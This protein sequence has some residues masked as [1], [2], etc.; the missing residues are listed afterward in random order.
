MKIIIHRGTHQIGGCVTEIKTDNTRMFIDMGSELDPGDS[1]SLKIE[2]VTKGESE[3]DAVLFS[4]YHGDHIGMI[5][6]INDDIPIYIGKAAKEILEIFNEQTKRYSVNKVAR[7][8]TYRQ[9][10]P[11]MIGELK[12]TPFS[13]DHSAYDSYMFLIE[14]NGFR[15]LHTGDFRTTGFR[16]K[17]VVPMLSKY[18]GKIDVLIT[19]G[20]LLTRSNNKMIT[21][22]DIM[23]SAKELIREHKYVFLLC[24]STNI[25]SLAAFYNATPKGKYFICDQYQKDIFECV[26]KYSEKY[27]PLYGFKKALTYGRNLLPKLKDRGFCMV[28]RATPCFAK[29]MEQFDRSES[30]IVYSMW[31][32][33]KKNSRMRA[34]LDGFAFK[35]IHTS[36]HADIQTIKDVCRTVSPQVVIP[37]HC[38]DP[39][40]FKELDLQA[41]VMVLQDKE[42]IELD[43]FIIN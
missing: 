21:E 28:V 22:R 30:I 11:I 39:D 1:S 15:I 3:C 25:D 43:N 18:V 29:K 20:T 32:G 41:D 36:G 17:G 37:I 26:K 14:A 24:S 2:G 16:G 40:E 23:A 34:F 27:T 13:V 9:A 12:V 33:Y 31:E 4:H 6:K 35:D 7:L 5:E 42:M 38:E 8:D 10:V 19:E